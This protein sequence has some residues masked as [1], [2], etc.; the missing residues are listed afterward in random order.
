[1]ATTCAY[2]HARKG[3]RQCPALNGL[4][5]PPCCGEN[6]LTKITCPADCPYLEAGTDYQRQRVHLR[7]G[8]FV[9]LVALMPGVGS[10]LTPGAAAGTNLGVDTIRDQ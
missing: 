8:L 2:C 10:R 9:R 3:K 5:C 1:M 6:R 7:G 4:I